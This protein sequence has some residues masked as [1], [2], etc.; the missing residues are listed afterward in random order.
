MS[1]D[2]RFEAAVAYAEAVLREAKKFNGNRDAF[3]SHGY[4]LDKAKML[5]YVIEQ[6]RKELKQ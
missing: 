2:V 1:S 3:F 5:V 6:G 4:A